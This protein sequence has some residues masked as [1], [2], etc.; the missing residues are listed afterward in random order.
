VDYYQA[1]GVERDATADEIERAYRRL[2]RQVHPDRSPNDPAAGDRMK[3]LNEIRATLTDPLLRSAYDDRLHAE[4]ADQ[5]GRARAGA[6][7]GTPPD[8]DPRGTRGGPHAREREQPHQHDTGARQAFTAGG[9]RQPEPRRDGFRG[10]WHLTW[11]AYSRA[12]WR[13]L[14]LAAVV[15]AAGLW[16]SRLVEEQGG[17]PNWVLDLLRVDRPRQQATTLPGSAGPA[18]PDV[19]APGAA[20]LASPS[21]APRAARRPSGVVQRGDDADEI[22]RKLGPPDRLEPGAL[23]G[24]AFLHYG[25]LRLELRQGRLVGTAP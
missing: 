25:G 23:P 5:G 9:W 21:P 4:A 12:F 16:G 7:T 2:A 10:P 1:L 18:A 24:Q 15:V 20:P 17:V 13:V 19:P 8:D 6:T 3:Q 22:R 14:A 11:R